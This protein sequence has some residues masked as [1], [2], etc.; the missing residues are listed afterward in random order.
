MSVSCCISNA[1]VMLV[2]LQICHSILFFMV[3]SFLLVELAA[4]K[5]VVLRHAPPTVIK[6]LVE[7]KIVGWIL[8][9]VSYIV[10][11]IR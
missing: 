4:K 10:I 11:A 2:A 1:R 3:T 8:V 9:V 7:T 6:L 5:P